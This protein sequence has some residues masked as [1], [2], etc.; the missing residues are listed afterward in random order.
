MLL[1]FCL[2]RKV[3]VKVNL[4]VTRRPQIH[5]SLS[6]QSGIMQKISEPDSF[7]TSP[8]HNNV[9]YVLLQGPQIYRQ[10]ESSLNFLDARGVI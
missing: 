1:V 2:G 3:E 9:H 10:S 7:S 4:A 6:L 5:V 8:S